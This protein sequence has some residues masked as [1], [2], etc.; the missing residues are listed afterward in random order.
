MYDE[1]QAQKQIQLRGLSSPQNGDE[2]FSKK[3]LSQLGEEDSELGSAA[4]NRMKG[5]GSDRN[6]VTFGQN[7][8][9]KLRNNTEADDP[10][11]PYHLHYGDPRS[12]RGP[13]SSDELPR[14][15]DSSSKYDQLRPN[16]EPQE[17]V[18]PLNYNLQMEELLQRI[19]MQSKARDSD[20]KEEQSLR[21]KYRPK[22]DQ[23]EGSLLDRTLDE[24]MRIAGPSSSQ[25]QKDLQ[26]FGGQNPRNMLLS[27]LGKSKLIH[28]SNHLGESNRAEHPATALPNSPNTK[29]F[30][31]RP[32]SVD[33]GSR[34]STQQSLLV[35][36]TFGGE[37]NN[38]KKQHGN[39][40]P[41]RENGGKS[42]VPSKLGFIKLK[43]KSS[44]VLGDDSELE[45]SPSSP[46]G[47]AISL[48]KPTNIW[49]EEEKISRNESKKSK[50]QYMISPLTIK[51]LCNT[52]RKAMR[53]S[54]YRHLVEH[55]RQLD[56]RLQQGFVKLHTVN[57]RFIQKSQLIA[58]E[59]IQSHPSL[60]DR[61]HSI[62]TRFAEVLEGHEAASKQQSLAQ[63]QTYYLTRT[64]PGF[65]S[66]LREALQVGKMRD[67]GPSSN[68]EPNHI[69]VVG[70]QILEQRHATFRRVLERASLRIKFATRHFLSLWLEQLRESGAQS[71]LRRLLP[72]LES[73]MSL[74]Q[75]ADILRGY[76]GIKAAG[77]R[78]QSLRIILSKKVKIDTSKL[79]LSLK[80]L[81]IWCRYRS[82]T[83]SDPESN[84]RIIIVR[85]EA[86][87]T[88]SSQLDHIKRMLVKKSLD[89][90]AKIIAQ[91]CQSQQ[92]Y[93]LS[94]LA[95]YVSRKQ[96]TA[97]LS[98]LLE[99]ILLKRPLRLG[100]VELNLTYVQRKSL[101]VVKAAPKET[102]HFSP[103][104]TR[105]LVG[106]KF[107]LSDDKKAP[108]SN[109]LF[110]Y[111][112]EKTTGS[113]PG[114]NMPQ[115]DSPASHHRKSSSRGFISSA[116]QSGSIPN[117]LAGS[118]GY[119]HSSELEI[120]R[121]GLD[122]DVHLQA[123]R[124]R[125][126]GTSNSGRGLIALETALKAETGYGTHRDQLRTHATRE[127]ALKL[128]SL[129]R[130]QLR[131]AFDRIERADTQSKLQRVREAYIRF[132]FNA[133]DTAV[134][135]S[136][137]GCKESAWHLLLKH[138]DAL[139]SSRQGTIKPV[140]LYRQEKKSVPNL[141][142]DSQGEKSSPIQDNS[143]VS[144][145]LSPNDSFPRVM[146][147][148]KP[149]LT[150]FQKPHPY[151]KI[152]DNTGLSSSPRVRNAATILNDQN[153]K[154]LTLAPASYTEK[155]ANGQT[156]LAKQGHVLLREESAEQKKSSEKQLLAR[157]IGLGVQGSGKPKIVQPAQ[158]PLGRY[159]NYQ[160]VK[161]KK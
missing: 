147:Q 135:Q 2:R 102:S 121:T 120:L 3:V 19:D 65:A 123:S 83:Q 54:V 156:D 99:P 112:E 8:V 108:T 18:S 154:G 129:C 158:R 42:E 139:K 32:G 130:R 148:P 89:T 86:S 60:V 152:V 63:L 6:L 23:A 82:N 110:R 77:G 28:N 105:D 88:Q 47:G 125:A 76:Y 68:Q 17:S 103:R 137:R 81:R 160:D 31:K 49:Q 44:R 87:D 45:I 39:K 40:K 27:G 75:W 53:Q 55:F 72:R 30:G 79:R 1:S 13:K 69:L 21:S 101:A 66:C 106:N 61:A 51:K 93:T 131:I 90:L 10:I 15:G 119:T 132:F 36:V 38:S 104:F 71:K 5:P 149:S 62:L 97:R 26:A 67:A 24:L 134:R 128:F 116:L 95:Q 73:I 25:S 142:G 43:G 146:T 92:T 56:E 138:S 117:L 144:N 151:M 136:N 64:L 41:V 161:L 150:L 100:W 74:A 85:S 57:A 35:P 34:R 155:Q 9:H 153:S 91:R 124:V 33:G 22:A 84:L 133:I 78:L 141:T 157:D 127:L 12:H 16:T 143:K 7:K 109:P 118:E 46:S 126:R 94:V 4:E 48:Q 122:L 20:K 58:L 113:Q 159:P 145:S 29:V 98:I 11:R 114:L 96:C 52:V 14:K 111:F 37:L 70:L 115:E 140:Y 59:R 107:T 50:L 80:K